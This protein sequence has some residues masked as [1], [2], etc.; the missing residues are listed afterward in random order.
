MRLRRLIRRSSTEPSFVVDSHSQF[1]TFSQTMMMMATGWLRSNCNIFAC[2]FEVC[3]FS[4][5]QCI[6]HALPEL[7]QPTSPRSSGASA[8]IALRE[9]AIFSQ[10]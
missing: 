1:F 10:V 5:A 7:E 9:R 8:R 3:R 4:S 6:H 2:A